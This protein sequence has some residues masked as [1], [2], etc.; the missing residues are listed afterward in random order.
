LPDLLGTIGD[1][2]RMSRPWRGGAGAAV[3]ATIA[4]LA[5]GNACAASMR[6]RDEGYLGFRTSSGSL[7]VDEGRLAGTLPGR[8]RVQFIY[9]GSPTVKATFT[10]VGPGWELRGAATCR[11]SHPNS[12]SPSFRGALTLTGGSGRYAHARG[13]GELFGVFY[14]ATS[15]GLKIQAV[16]NVR[17]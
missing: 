9:D 4:L 1:G 2:W 14:R 5:A 3:S 13:S 17:Y 6:I 15:Y 11:L 16:G 12:S 10:I 8:A 7:V